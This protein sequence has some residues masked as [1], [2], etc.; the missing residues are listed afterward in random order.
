MIRAMMSLV[1]I[2]ALLLTMRPGLANV[3]RDAA[4]ACDADVH[5]YLERLPAVRAAERRI[6]GLL[7]A[8]RYR[9]AIPALKSAAT[10]Y[11]DPW[12]GDTL[13]DLYAAGLGVPRSA[14]AAAHWYL[15]SAERG[16]PFA[17]WWLADTYLNGVGVGRDTARAAYWFRIGIAPYELAR[18]D[19]WLAGTY[20]SGNLAPVNRVKE[21][22]Y[23]N[24]SLRILRKLAREPNGEADFDL[25]RAYAGGYGVARDRKMALKLFCRALALGCEPAVTRI[26]KLEQPH[27]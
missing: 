13:A 2:P 12:A 27:R 24:E 9:W 10:R 23:L 6:I 25:A 18:S 16:D 21:R 22:Y 5:R 15:W 20:A 17:Q 26:R 11:G 3:R 8:K 4:G 7:N 14:S 19:Y 1:V